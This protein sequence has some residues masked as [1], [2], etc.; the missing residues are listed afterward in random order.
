[1]T[2]HWDIYY[3]ISV[4][5]YSRKIVLFFYWKILIVNYVL[6][7]TI[8]KLI[9]TQSDCRFDIKSFLFSSF[10]LQLLNAKT[11][12]CFCRKTSDD[13]SLFFLS[14]EYFESQNNFKTFR[15]SETILSEFFFRLIVPFS[16]E[17]FLK[18]NSFLLRENKLTEKKLFLFC[19]F[20]LNAYI[21][22][23]TQFALKMKL[24]FWQIF[25]IN[26]YKLLQDIFLSWL[27]FVAS[28]PVVL[29]DICWCKI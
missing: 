14:E 24:L 4:D 1:V 17:Y 21:L 27:A 12:S 22:R 15:F 8:P 9:L 13:V 16:L 23:Y 2:T 6:F 19:N 25:M 20:C 18:L 10:I 26:L 11:F 3:S 7:R 5:K 28:T 29:H